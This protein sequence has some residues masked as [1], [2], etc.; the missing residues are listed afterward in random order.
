[1]F[2]LR[3]AVRLRAA[4]L[5]IK[6]VISETPNTGKDIMTPDYSPRFY[7]SQSLN[8]KRHVVDS[9]MEELHNQYF[10]MI[11]RALEHSDMRQ[12]RDVIEYV[13]AL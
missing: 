9:M 6:Y 3:L 12:A 2:C 11:E 5:K 13:Q 7:K 4:Q 1:V 10:D 8:R